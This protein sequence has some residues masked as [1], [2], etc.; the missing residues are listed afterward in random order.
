MP[1]GT[2]VA[3]FEASPEAVWKIITD[4]ENATDWVPDLISVQRLDSGPMGVGSRFKEL[5]N[6]QG[7]RVEML[8]TVKEFDA[9]LVIAHSGEGGSVKISGRATISE[10]QTGCRV[11]NDWSVELSGMLRLA[12]PL[13]GAW[14][15]KNIEDS[16]EALRGLLSKPA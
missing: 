5:V 13:A 3:E 7:R 6:V 9:P 10:T 11:S 8:V 14:T 12:S 15:R 2:V 4:L 1:S 16:M